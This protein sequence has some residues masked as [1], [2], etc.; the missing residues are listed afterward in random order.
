M[1]LLKSPANWCAPLV[2]PRGLRLLPMTGREEIAGPGMLMMDS[3]DCQPPETIAD[4]S[5]LRQCFQVAHH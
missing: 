4:N 2:I 5:D 1:R 3:A